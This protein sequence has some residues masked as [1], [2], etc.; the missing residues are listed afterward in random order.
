MKL[1]HYLTSAA[2]VLIIFLFAAAHILLPEGDV[3]VSERRPLEQFPEVTVQSVMNGSFGDQLEEYLLD[4]FPLREQLRS[5]KAL[6]HFDV[7]GQSDNNGIYMVGDHVLK[8][9]SALKEAEVS[10][11]IANTNKVYE[12]YLQGMNVSFAL[13]PDKNY[14]AAA[15][16]GYPA[17]D[18]ALM[19]QLLQN[20][21]NGDIRYLGMTP[22]ADLTLDDYYRTDLH[23]KQEA[24]QPVVNALAQTLDFIPTELDFC[25]Q[26]AYSP[27][28]GSYYGQSALNIEPDVLTT[29]SNP[30]I[31]QC[32]VTSPEFKGEKPVYDAADFEEMDGYNVFL[33]GPLG[34]VTVENPNGS[35]GKELILFRDSFASSLAPLLMEGYDKI[36]LVDLRYL[37]SINV[38]RFVEFAD[39]DVLFLYSTTQVNSGKLLK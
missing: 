12:S 16:N 25:D 20:G 34:I 7:Y 31:D 22:F 3:S 1:R 19:E 30:A 8:L 32:I 33:G 13:I 38:G 6:W 35:T 21:L 36:T 10:A 28:Y 9:D 17:L 14:F 23:W 24:L 27:F 18:Y 5:L 11:L 26:T 2:F 15:E 39:Q 29:F 4:Q 37:A